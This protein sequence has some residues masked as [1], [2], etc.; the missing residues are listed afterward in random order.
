MVGTA[1]TNGAGGLVSPHDN[2]VPFLMLLDLVL[3]SE[4]AILGC[5][6]ASGVVVVVT[7]LLMVS[8]EVVSVIVWAGSDDGIFSELSSSKDVTRLLMVP[9]AETSM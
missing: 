3:A 6:G 7:A 8:T 2:L 4:T 1:Y 5:P 9:V